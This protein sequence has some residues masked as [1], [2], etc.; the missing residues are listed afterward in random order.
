MVSRVLKRRIYRVD[1]ASSRNGLYKKTTAPAS[2]A[3]LTHRHLCSQVI[4][5]SP[6]VI[7]NEYHGLYFGHKV[8]S[9]LVG[10]VNWNVAPLSRFAVA[11]S[12]VDEDGE[13]ALL[14]R[15]VTWN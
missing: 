1:Q 7:D 12:E 15:Q 5:E 13:H 10:K 3:A 8:L 11:Q 4:R 9:R 6:I 2:R 14:H